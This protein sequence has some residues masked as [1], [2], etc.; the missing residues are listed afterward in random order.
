[1]VRVL[2][3]EWKWKRSERL[4]L[5]RVVGN[6]SHLVLLVVLGRLWMEAFTTVKKGADKD[7]QT[8]R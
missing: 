3:T 6:V 1:M 4:S 2:P 5:S 7:E 8:N